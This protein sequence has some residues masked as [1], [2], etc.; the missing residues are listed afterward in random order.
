MAP[1]GTKPSAEGVVV[2]RPAVIVSDVV[3]SR[4]RRPSPMVPVAPAPPPPA[5]D[6]PVENIFGEDLVSEKSLDEV[7]LAYLSEDLPGK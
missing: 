7:I 3:T 1:Y 5:R 2:A 4:P 6:A